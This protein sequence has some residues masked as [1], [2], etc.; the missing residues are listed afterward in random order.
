MKKTLA[1]ILATIFTLT[2]YAQGMFNHPDSVWLRG[3]H[4]SA[5][6]GLHIEYS[7]D[8]KTWVKI[9]DGFKVVSSDFGKWGQQKKM[10]SP[11]LSYDGETFHCEWYVGENIPQYAVTETKDLYLWKPQE[12][13]FL[14]ES[15]FQ[16]KKEYLKENSGKAVRVPYAIVDALEGNVQAALWR[17]HKESENMRGDGRVF[18]EIERV[19]YTLDI[20]LSNSKE[21][22]PMLYGIFF[23]DINYAADGGLYAELV[24]NRDFEYSKKDNSKWNSK[25]AWK[26]EGNAKWSIETS[27]PIHANNPHYAR[28]ENEE[29]VRLINTGFDGIPLKA[30]EKYELSFFLRGD[31]KKVRV[32]L[33]DSTGKVVAYAKSLQKESKLKGTTW[34]R[35]KAML[36]SEVT[37]DG[38]RLVVEFIS[39]GT[40]DIDFVS[41]FPT[42]TYKGRKNGLRRDLAEALAAIHPKFVRFPGGCLSHGDGIDNIYHW[43]ASIGELWERQSDFNI[44]NYHQSRG[45]GF[46]EYFQFCEDI[47]AEP[48]PVLPAGVPCQNSGNGGHGQMGGVPFGESKYVYNGKPFN[49]ESYLQELLD[50]IEWANGDAKTSALAA[51]RAKAGHPQP[52]NLKYLGVGN[53]DLIGE[54]F[55]E[56]FKYL[57]D[58]IRAKYPEITI[59]GTVGPF[60]EGSDYEYGWKLAR[61]KDV[62][63]VDEHYYNPVGWYLNNQD[64]Y[65]KYSREG[66]KVYL[67]E[68]ASK[69][70]TMENAL[71]EALY[72]CHLERNADV[73]TMSSYAPLLAREGHTQWNPDMIYFNNTELKPTPNY[74]VQMM[75][76]Q[77]MGETFIYAK[78]SL[79]TGGKKQQ[80]AAKRIKNS[81]TLD[82]TT[83]DLIVKVV[84]ALP[85][86]TTL[87][88]NVPQ[89]WSH[90]TVTTISGKPQ[91][92][93]IANPAIQNMANVPEYLTLPAYSYQVIR[94]HK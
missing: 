29:S 77:N 22:S 76:G 68:W 51:E 79:N 86:E 55:A 16:A 47:G 48:L 91:D 13:P 84:N 26:M 88:L 78:E 57:Y 87:H 62:P 19:N 45:L 30:S 31:Y 36:T 70:N 21:V 52:F 46:Y 25:T 37:C 9:G 33:T 27:E 65:D 50:L 71:A 49:M 10:Y 53:E 40:Y 11:V 14:T 66:T 54:V 15:E 5:T 75:A 61:E 23:E 17:K 69:G 44:W 32:A 90:A 2:L 6:S 94:L 64:F 58:G 67:G 74:Y 7:V 3:V 18:S 43:Q 4:N 42:D 92:R 60:F 56:R 34:T 73:V 28:I 35:Y 12:Y 41:L 38:A 24:Q 85:L 8:G 39:K 93:K 81:V 63:V 82:K 89:G 80:E 72:M 1:T 20:D 59:V 83:G